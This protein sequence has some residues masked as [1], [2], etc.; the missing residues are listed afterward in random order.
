MPIAA[1]FYRGINALARGLTSA[2]ETVGHGLVNGIN[3]AGEIAYDV[4]DAIGQKE[5][6]L[7]DPTLTRLGL[8]SPPAAPRDTFAERGYPSYMTGANE[9]VYKRTTYQDWLGGFDPHTL[10]KQLPV[11]NAYRA[12]PTGKFGGKDGLETLPTQ[13]SDGGIF[14]AGSPAQLYAYTRA[15]QRAVNHYP[16]MPKM[17]A[18]QLAAL[19]I[20]EGRSDFGHSTQD[21]HNRQSQAMWNNLTQL[22]IGDL[23]ASFATTIAEK[24]AVAKRLNIPF[25]EAWNGTGKNHNG[26]SGA[27]YAKG[28]EYALKAA[29]HPKNKQLVDFIQ[30][31]LDA[32]ARDR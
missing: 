13:F 17:N 5:H 24:A 27:Q 29:Q 30:S 15:Y 31:A 12:D 7:L 6:Q 8:R 25:A 1:G 26:T 22:G 32:G 9:D 28:F 23:P 14:K 11:I 18:T 19:A 20:K 3:R 2:G 16:D 10:P 21:V 4:G